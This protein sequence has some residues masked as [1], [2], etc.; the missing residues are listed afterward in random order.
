MSAPELDIRQDDLS[1]GAIRGLLAFHLAGMRENSPP[2]TSY[3]LDLS[4]LQTPEVT[5]WSAWLGDEI[6]GCGALSEIGPDWG[7]VKS[8]RTATAHLR[9]G[10]AAAL[11]EHV[12]ATARSRGYR[13]LSLETGASAEYDAAATL[14]RK[15]GFRNG[16]IFA[17]YTPSPHNQFMHLDL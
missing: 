7:E 15:R 13:R 11:L 4:E 10:V 16:D 2:G 14:Y 3:A 17:D 5:V 6:A 8:M 12:I 9:K 1:G